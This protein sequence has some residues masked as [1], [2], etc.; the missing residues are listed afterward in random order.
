[1]P[2]QTGLP[3]LLDG[4]AP[5]VDLLEPS[6]GSQAK[7]PSAD[8]AMRALMP[9]PCSDSASMRWACRSACT[10][11]ADR[12]CTR[13]GASGVSCPRR[14]PLRSNCAS[15]QRC[16][17]GLDFSRCT[18]SDSNPSQGLPAASVMASPCHCAVPLTLSEG[19]PSANWAKSTLKRVASWPDFRR[20]GRLLGQ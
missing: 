14:K 11:R 9:E 3:N 10:C 2:D 13:K 18:S 7:V 15:C 20:K 1:M 19:A 6:S 4:A 17:K 8:R 5:A 12:L 16:C